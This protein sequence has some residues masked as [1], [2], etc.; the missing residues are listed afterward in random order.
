[1][2]LNP[3]EETLNSAGDY[4]SDYCGNFLYRDNEL[5]TIFTP[6]G[7]IVPIEYA[8]ETF[9]QY[10][11]DMK[12]HL[13]NT[14][15]VFAAHDNGHPEV[16]QQTSYYPYGK[17]MQQQNF[18]GTDANE[19]KNLFNGKE[20]QDDVL[21]GINLDW[22]DFGARMYDPEICRWHVMDPLAV[23]SPNYSPYRFGF[24]NPIMFTDPSG[25]YEEDGD[26]DDYGDRDRIPPGADFPDVVIKALGPWWEGLDQYE[27]R[28]INTIETYDSFWEAF[29][30]QIYGEGSGHNG[31]EIGTKTDPN[32]VYWTFN[33]KEFQ[34]VMG[35]VV[36]A[37]SFGDKNEANNPQLQIKLVENYMNSNPA[38]GQ[39]EPF[40]ITSDTKFLV[41]YDLQLNGDWTLSDA[42]KAKNFYD[43]VK[44]DSEKNVIL[45]WQD[46]YTDEWK[47]RIN[48][49]KE[50]MPAGQREFI[51]GN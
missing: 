21:A 23:L 49:P 4:T 48:S 3:S 50:T 5:I 14:R 39:T 24:N 32:K 33:Y 38:G 28:A 29:G 41:V 25:M 26:G 19:N 31:Y 30:I 13:G 34:K 2:K 20:F 8:G 27:A 47:E 1:V 46:G 18:Q 42:M 37:S 44:I 10:E 43:T 9:W 45:I 15:L 22:Y 51:W 7:R 36:S 35:I 11:Y 16:L 12:D 40:I 17:I 6:A